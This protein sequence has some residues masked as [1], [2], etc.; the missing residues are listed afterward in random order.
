MARR[1][2]TKPLNFILAFTFYVF[3]VV[4]VLLLRAII[5]H[6]NFG[7]ILLTLNYLLRYL[8]FV[9]FIIAGD[10]IK[11]EFSSVVFLFVLQQDD[12]RKYK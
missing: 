2:Y 3:T 11:Y 5:I 8:I 1:M 12:I 10:K 4:V 7:F 9:V 6:R